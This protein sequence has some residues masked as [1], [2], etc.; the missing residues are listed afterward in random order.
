[1]CYEYGS[2]LRGH[3][4][5]QPDVT[6]VASKYAEHTRTILLPPGSSDHLP[7]LVSIEEQVRQQVI[8]RKRK[9]RLKGA[10]Y[11]QFQAKMRNALP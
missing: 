8:H 2:S 5:T 3:G 7:I 11:A 10:D 4:E 6:V 1:M 9:W